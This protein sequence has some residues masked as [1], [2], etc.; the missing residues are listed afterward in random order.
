MI[1][2]R[3][4]EFMQDI[5]WGKNVVRDTI[6]EHNRW[7]VRHELIFKE[8]DKIFRAH[9]HV[10]ATE[11]QEEHPWEHEDPVKVVEVKAVSIS[12]IEYQEIG[13]DG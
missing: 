4:K 8:G 6:V 9:Y 3:S 7:T 5:L 12:T 1:E 11:Y 13:V 2:T 10:G